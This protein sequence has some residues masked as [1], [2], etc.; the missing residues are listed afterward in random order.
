MLFLHPEIGINR[1]LKTQIAFN[2]NSNEHLRV[3]N[4][5]TANSKPRRAAESGK[6]LE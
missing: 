2:I 3:C 6:H 4:L 5:A 1:I